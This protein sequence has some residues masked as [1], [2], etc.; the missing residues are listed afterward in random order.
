MN[1]ELNNKLHGFV[2]EQ[3][4][5]IED[6][7]GTLYMFR[8]EQTNAELCWLKRDDNNKTFAITFKTIP[9][10]DT[11]V[12]HIL[13]H[14]VLNGSKKYPVREPF[15]ELLKSSLQT[16]LNAFTYPDKTMYPVS[17]R[18]NKDYMNLI[19]VYMDAVF[20][21]AIYT[22][23]N[24]FLQEGWHYQIHD[25]NEEMEYS[26][27]VLNEMKGAFSSVDETIV[28]ELNR[29]LFPDNCYKYVSGGD[30]RYIT[31][32]TY[33]QFI[34]TH[35]KFYHPSNA[36]IWV[37]GSLDIDE[38]LRFIHEEY[39][40]NYQKEEMDF[41]IPMQKVLPAVH[42]RIS[43]EVSENEPTE[44]RSHISFAKI[45]STYDSY[46]QNIAWSALSSTLVA[47]NESPLKK[48]I[49]DNNLGEDVD[50]DLYDGIQQP[51]L[52][53]TIRNT[54]A[55]KYDAIRETLRST[56]S[57]LVENG[58]DHEELHAT[59]N[60]MEFRYRESHEPAGLMYGQRAMDSWLYGGDPAEPLFNGKIF[61]ILREKIEQ[62]YFEELLASF[63]LDEEHLNSLTVV[64]STTM[65]AER[66]ADEKKRLADIKASSK[67][68]VLKYIEQNKALDL[69]QQST[70]TKEQ[71]ATLP[72]IHLSEIDEKPEDLPLQ[73]EKVQS[74]KTLVHPAQESGIVYL[75][76]YFS[77][78]GITIKHLPA[79]GLFTDLL[80]NL[81]TTKKTVRELQRAV[82]KD[83]GSLN[84]VTD[85]YSPD[86]RSDACI[87][88]LAVTCS[89][90]ERNVDKVVPLILE[91]IKD[92]KFT[93]EEILPILKQGNEGARQS[94]IMN[95][96]SFAMRRV[97]AHH[98]AEGVFREYI[99]GYENAL[100]SKKLE[101][102]YDELIDEVINE[103]EMYQEVL[104]SKD[105]LIASVTGDHLDV[106]E[107]FI[108]GINRIEAQGN[109]V[110][111][112][113]L[114]E[115]KEAL[116]IPAGISYSAAGTN[117]KSFD[118][119]Y[120]PCL[121]VIA[122]LLTYDYLWTEVR[123]KGNAY[124]TGFSAN[125]NGNI[126]AYSYRDPSPLHSIEIYRDT[127]KRIKQLAEDEHTDLAGYIIG[128]IAA[129]EPLLSPAAKVRLADI[130]YFRNTT[131]ENL[132]T[133][134][135]K[136]LSMTREDLARY[137]ELFEKALQNPTSCIVANTETIEQCKEEGYTILDPIS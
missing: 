3:I 98:S 27:V 106:V 60:Q 77:L 97:S 50:L 29:M 56:T 52:V 30:P 55:K 49:L 134:R 87:P 20:Q 9:D 110:H 69:W 68:N 25:V 24:I 26:G 4:K 135:K 107:E 67:E 96:H 130:R 131:Y 51:W 95:G 41:A 61:D 118:F 28:D 122:H 12:F 45:I 85:V 10:N 111:Y 44:N 137:V 21:P 91:V 108:A 47:N 37:D 13:E 39:F 58:L 86:N 126:A 34:E 136:I 81:P 105:R 62:G 38:V 11:G 76:F 124:G 2:L 114:Q 127:Y 43:Y 33:E 7:K 35:Q 133:A 63:L 31:D 75:F 89:V 19:S 22:N 84:I 104:F 16:F 109:V 23:P 102:N 53:L 103:F 100:F 64:P 121:Q 119:E 46:V 88:V 99:G 92:T 80:M 15:V 82:R 66:I 8:H 72:K 83:L 73:I 48:A 17:S 65:G 1:L 79:V 90:L 117:I 59:I 32:L 93:K 112:P 101:D 129:A 6:A 40:V 115:P 70:D 78:A 36:R 14:S 5:D 125:P 116:Q 57:K 42:N 71:L 120:D 94:I 18:N 54:D 132:C 74:V 113:L 128:T 123:V